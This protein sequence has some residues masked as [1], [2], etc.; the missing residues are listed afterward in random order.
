[1]IRLLRK[2]AEAPSHRQPPLQWSPACRP[3]VTAVEKR[4]VTEGGLARPAAT[5]RS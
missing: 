2:R 1:M 4:A 5:G 3:A